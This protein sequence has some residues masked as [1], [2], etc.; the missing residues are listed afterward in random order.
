[1][2]KKTIHNITTLLF[3]VPLFS[4]GIYVWAFEGLFHIFSD[5]S[6]FLRSVIKAR[7]GEVECLILGDSHLRDT[8]RGLVE[9]CVNLSEGGISV[10][11]LI[12]GIDSVV[13][14]NPNLD[15][16]VLVWGPHLFARYRFGQIGPE[17]EGIAEWFNPRYNPLFMNSIAR[18]HLRQSIS[19]FRLKKPKRNRDSRWSRRSEEERSRR[20][21]RR[22][23]RHRPVKEFMSTT[24]YIDYE[25][26]IKQLIDL[27]KTVCL[28]RTPVSIEYE[29][30][31]NN[32]Y[33]SD[34]WLKAESQIR[35]IEGLRFIDSK[36]LEIP[37][38]SR[39]FRNQDHLSLSGAKKI[40]KT[41]L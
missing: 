20:A 36:N 32:V 17:Y 4:V 1:M 23:S 22:S 35:S 26:K 5:K 25:S 41:Y 12:D 9:D 16:V 24:F 39:D 7:N 21:K 10:P 37:L 13:K 14:S 31:M 29:S 34:E 2:K 11:M 40:F 3:F 19:E 18:A 8:F 28:V 27:N 33:N 15:K 6:E 30:F 38:T